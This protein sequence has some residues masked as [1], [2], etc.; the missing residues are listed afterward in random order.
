MN[1]THWEVSPKVT[2]TRLWFRVNSY[3][4][5]EKRKI[6]KTDASARKIESQ[7]KRGRKTISKDIKELVDEG[8]LIDNGKEY[9]IIKPN[10][11][12]S[13]PTDFGKKMISMFHQDVIKIYS[14]LYQKYNYKTNKM[15]QPCLFSYKDLIVDALG[16]SYNQDR[17]ERIKPFLY[18]LAL[19]GLIVIHTMKVKE[20]KTYL[21]WLKEIRTEFIIMDLIDETINRNL[22]DSKVFEGDVDTDIDFDELELGPSIG[23]T[24]KMLEQSSEEEFLVDELPKIW[25][26]KDKPPIDF[27]P[28]DKLRMILNSDFGFNYKDNESVLNR[29]QNGWGADLNERYVEY[30]MENW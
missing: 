30:V 7:I 10:R 17:I 1:E 21:F 2:S 5:G 9:E 14:W 29:L 4:D 13:I 18:Q 15:H 20:G 27:V 23:F 22:N 24:N 28:L 12:I 26:I 19:N 11:Y 25:I 8:V 6:K 16:L 3:W